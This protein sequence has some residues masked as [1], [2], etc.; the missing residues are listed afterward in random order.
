MMPS[1]AVVNHV[2][3]IVEDPQMRNWP[4]AR[5]K[6]PLPQRLQRCLIAKGQLDA[7]DLGL[8]RLVVPALRRFASMLPAGP[9]GAA[10]LRYRSALADRPGESLCG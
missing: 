2:A 4:G 10:A 7:G 1:G 5:T 9:A 3:Y 8:G 6:A